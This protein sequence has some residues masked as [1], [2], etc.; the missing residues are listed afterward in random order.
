MFLF[1]LEGWEITER[2]GFFSGVCNMK[3]NIYIRKIAWNLNLAMSNCIDQNIINNI[4]DYPLLHLI[5]TI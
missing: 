4:F 1:Y 3:C 2:V 5:I